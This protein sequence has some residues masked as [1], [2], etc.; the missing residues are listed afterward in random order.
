MDLLS[1]E[2][3]ER[4]L[5]WA[6]AAW[7]AFVFVWYL[8]FKFTGHDGSVHLFTVLT[9]WLGLHGHEKA[10]RI[11]TGAAEL[12]AAALCL[13]P[14]TRAL[15]AA[16]SFAIMAGAIFFHLVSPLGIDPYGDGGTLFKEACATLLASAVLLWFARRQAVDL[17]WRVPLLGA[18][19][20]RIA[21][22]LRRPPRRRTVYRTLPLVA[23]AWL[24]ATA[25]QPALAGPAE[26]VRALYERFAT[27]QNRRDLAAV[28]SLLLPS[29]RFLWVSDGMSVWGPEA[30][31]A[32]MASFQ[33]YDVWHVVPD[34]A[35]AVAVEI[36][37][38]SGYLHL[39][40]ALTLGPRVPGPA[41]HRFLVSMLAVE[42][43]A[44]WRIA[45]LFTTAEK[46][47]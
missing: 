40:L 36:D 35:D 24:A 31:I 34:L 41:T 2:S 16:L 32:R 10:M 27:A 3:I 30:T 28:R 39:P 19:L 44:G 26:E 46:P 15:G 8:Q 20:P 45:A 25:A 11:G 14:A 43:G 4:Y 29:P 5:P 6:L 9:D 21:P 1:R 47:R 33:E 37:A 13:V 38:H 23:A 17:A 7:I 12:V 22:S 42:T 18:L